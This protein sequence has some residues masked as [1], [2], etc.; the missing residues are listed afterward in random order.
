MNQKQNCA[1]VRWNEDRLTFREREFLNVQT[2]FPRFSK[3]MNITNRAQT[4]F[5][6]TKRIGKH[7]KINNNDLRWR[8]LRWLKQTNYR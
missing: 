5:E 4:V 2:T 7:E 1:L 8:R 6:K 3:E